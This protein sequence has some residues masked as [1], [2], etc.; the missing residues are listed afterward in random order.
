MY[1]YIYTSKKDAERKCSTCLKMPNAKCA[2]L[3]LLLF[4]LFGG[5]IPY[6]MGFL[7]AFTQISGV[8]PSCFFSPKVWAGGLKNCSTQRFGPLNVVEIHWYKMCVLDQ[9]KNVRLNFQMFVRFPNLVKYLSPLRYRICILNNRYIPITQKV[10]IS[11][12]CT[13]QEIRDKPDTQSFRLWCWDVRW[14]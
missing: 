4:Y 1:I 3:F 2:H 12:L 8:N 13:N 5:W 14:S 10:G 9:T 7:K 11:T 6:P